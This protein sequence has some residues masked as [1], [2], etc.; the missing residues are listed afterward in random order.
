MGNPAEVAGDIVSV[1]FN[2]SSVRRGAKR[3][4]TT[5]TTVFNNLTLTFD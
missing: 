4:S 3:T 5:F 1:V 2:T